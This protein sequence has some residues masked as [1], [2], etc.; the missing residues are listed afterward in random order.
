MERI[1]KQ[2]LISLVWDLNGIINNINYEN[3]YDRVVQF[4][5]LTS[6]LEDNLSEIGKLPIK[7]IH[8]HRLA[9]FVIFGF[10]SKARKKSEE[11]RRG[12][13]EKNK[14]IESQR[15]FFFKE[16]R[17]AGR[18]LCGRNRTKPGEQVTKHNVYFGNTGGIWT[19]PVAKFEELKDDDY[20]QSK[21]RQQIVSFVQGYKDSFKL[22][23]LR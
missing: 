22:D 3:C 16:V 15:D 23:W 4:F 2:S 7:C 9:G 21:I 18:D 5:G 1:T 11:A 20:V 17:K 12:A 6:T 8:I 14:R 19:F 13:E 10:K